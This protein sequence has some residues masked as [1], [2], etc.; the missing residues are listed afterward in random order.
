ML[1]LIHLHGVAECTRGT[2]HNGNLGDRRG[3]GLLGSH[4][5][6]TDL[7]VRNNLLLLGAEHGVLALR[8][9]NDGLYALIQIG[10]NDTV[11]SKTN[12]TQSRLVD[13]VGEVSTGRTRSCT[14]NRVKV[15]IA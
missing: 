10:L 12:G 1:A 15:D 3:V 4:Q 11:A 6:V 14:G 8:T 2:R 7:V 5:C 13:D 9:G